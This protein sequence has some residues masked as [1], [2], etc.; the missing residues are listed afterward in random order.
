MTVRYCFDMQCKAALLVEK[1]LVVNKEPRGL[2]LEQARDYCIC[3]A[4]GSLEL[5]APP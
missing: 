1:G 5:H 2:T 3:L 4:M